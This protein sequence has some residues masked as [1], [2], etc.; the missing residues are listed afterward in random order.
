MLGNTTWIGFSN[1]SR[2]RA[3]N[4][5]PISVIRPRNSQYYFIMP[6]DD[7]CTRNSKLISAQ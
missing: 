3:K 1:L 4:H 5:F 2:S 7:I 6:I